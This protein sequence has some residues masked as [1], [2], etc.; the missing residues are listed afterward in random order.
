MNPAG[1]GRARYELREVLGR[2][3][4]GVIYK[5]YDTLMR[6][7]VALKTIL[8]IQ[9]KS[10]LDLFYREWGLQASIT[11][12]NVAEIYDIGQM[13]LEGGMKP[14]FVMPLL[15]GATLTDLLRTAPHRL[16]SDKVVDMVSQIC[17]GLQAAHDKGLIHRD[18]KPSNIFVLTD[19]SVKIIDFGIAHSDTSAQTSVRGTLSYMAPEL[20]QMKPA[21]VATD[22]FAL[23]VLTYEV[24]T[25]RRPFEG[26][27]DADLSRAILYHNPPPASEINTT[28]SQS[29]ARVV[30]KAIAKQPWNRY[31]NA[32]EFGDT[33]QKAQRGE[34][35]EF[36]DPAK[37]R[38][39]V[40]RAQRA[41]ERGEYPV[42]T[43]ILN[44]LESEGHIDQE[45]SM[46]RRQVEQT[47]RQVM[48]KQYLES[49]RRFFEEEE[50]QLAL[51]KIQEAMELDPNNTDT[52]ALKNEVEK[53]RREKK[54]EEWAQLAKKHLENNA[55][56]HAR[57]AIQSLLELKPN[58]P[59]G[60]ALLAD[61]KRREDEFERLR[62]E[63]SKLYAGARDAWE[64]GEVT[65]AL[66]NLDKYAQ[67]DRTSPETDGERLMAFQNFYKTVRGEHEAIKNSYDKARR[68]LQDGNYGES[69]QIC[70]QYLAKYP[71]H[72]LFQALKFDVE[73]RQRQ[74]MSAFIAE[75]DRRVES[76]PDLDRRVALLEEALK[77]SPGEAHFERA[78]KLTRDK[79]DLVSGVVSKARLHEDQGRYSEALDQ[80][81]VLRA[82]HSPYPGLDY[83]VERVK[84]RRDAQAFADAKAQWV[85]Q[86]DRQLETRDYQRAQDS[87]RQALGEFPNDQELI[88]LQKLAKQKEEK[89]A[90]ALRVLE[91]GR[92]ALAQG[93]RDEGLALMRKAYA[94]DEGNPV[95]KPM[96]VDALAEQAR[97]LL[98]T[99]ADA[100]DS[101][102]REALELDPQSSQV[103]HLR[104]LRGDRKKE[105]FIGWCTAQARKLQAANELEGAI[106]VVQQGLA[107]Y[108]NDARLNQLLSTLDRS[109]QEQS[110]RQTRKRDLELLEK[111]SEQIANAK[112]VGEVQRISNEA[113]KLTE[114]YKGDEEF[115]RVLGQIRQRASALSAGLM[116]STVSVP[117]SAPAKPKQPAPPPPPQPGDGG[118]NLGGMQT[119]P[120]ASVAAPPKQRP[121]VAGDTTLTPMAKVAKSRRVIWALLAA[122]IVI[123]GAG[124]WA[125][126]NRERPLPPPPSAKVEIK[127]TPP[128]ATIRIAG[129]DRGVSNTTLELQ[130]GEYKAE[131]LLDGFQATVT[132]FTVKDAPISVDIP[133]V[134]W[135]P[136]LR[137]SSELTDGQATLGDKPMNPGQPGEFLQDALEPG[138]YRLKFTSPQGEATAGLQFDATKP[139]MVNE[140]LQVKNLRLVLINVNADRAVVY[141]SIPG[142]KA[143]IDGQAAA[144]IPPEGLSV[145]GLSKGPHQ[146]LLE[147]GTTPR[148]LALDLTGGP[149]TY[150]YVLPRADADF[151]WVVLTTNED[152]GSIT[153]NG[154]AHPFKTKNGV[155]RLA[156]TKPGKY[157]LKVAKDGY[158][159]TPAQ[160]EVEVEK[161]KEVKAQ[162]TFKAI[163]RMAKL[164]LSGLPAGGQLLIDSKVVGTLNPDGTYLGDVTPGQHVLEVHRGTLKSKPVT[165]VFS[166][167]QT[168]TVNSELALVQPNGTIRLLLTPSDAK[169]TIRLSSEPE[170]QAKPFGPNPMSVPE[171]TYTISVSA[172]QYQA[173]TKVMT[174]ASGSATDFTFNLKK[175]AGETKSPGTPATPAGMSDF[176]DPAGWDFDGTW[177]VRKGGEFVTFSKVPVSGTFTF[178]VTLPK[179][180]KILGMGDKSFQ[181][182]V[183]F[184]GGQNYVLYRI[185]KN[186]FQ[187][188]DRIN[189][190]N[191]NE[192]KKAHG[193]DKD[194]SYEIRVD[195]DAHRIVN[196][197]LNGG[198]AVPVDEIFDS[199]RDFTKGKFGFYIPRNDEYAVK[200]FS[201]VPKK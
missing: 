72:A 96:V 68:L 124:V 24:L 108:P 57:G 100:A 69:L 79:R 80:W 6:R 113:A 171:G 89:Q 196:Y 16:T 64:R 195:V 21:S 166:A 18:L 190:K 159:V 73:E 12:P 50:Y 160:V 133:L 87:T 137:L 112:D 53:K 59:G 138:S 93:R 132:T 76:E 48:V 27:N 45:I 88:E 120:A 58:D 178:T 91:Q 47:Q 3:G 147:D 115:Q 40:E 200:S 63:K 150:A 121:A 188:V 162:F 49:A 54:I 106:A 193:L 20:L 163:V 94:I 123:L 60:L 111:F 92:E 152:N 145:N 105:E 158:E 156:I 142:A 10:A 135:K 46:L 131:F 81:E 77:A 84:K 153:I 154:F 35:I 9:S 85:T 181:W 189:G 71:G 136:F 180:K 201:Y 186:N 66:S 173:E 26:A 101:L 55:F 51:R 130:P 157:V 170:S 179:G 177:Y 17:R 172:P 192:P 125:V 7:E 143:G 140:P 25:R 5:A 128:G 103:Q 31:A 102:I 75:T 23:G 8:D 37:V 99:D 165:K 44:E 122:G 14:Y 86:I 42:A 169:V 161:A 28:V 43:E 175:L 183:G 78:L 70:Q 61:V 146:L 95:L 114:Q 155:Q 13:E 82:I 164:Q 116:T 139:P 151:G 119:G 198:K 109:K 191:T 98:E 65:A 33:L 126:L 1:K 129:V 2:G 174:V 83:E 199:G 22:I 167:G 38:P 185:D 4:M 184:T 144:L 32:R 149:G 168:V 107:S 117:S 11:H 104:A 97:L 90:E 134:G 62:G 39:R 141:A 56:V 67:L 127:T 118:M 30:Q 74:N 187:R 34:P 182:F 36:F 52:A 197:I 176:D 19:D 110:R 41:F 29:V 148:P 15:P 194:A